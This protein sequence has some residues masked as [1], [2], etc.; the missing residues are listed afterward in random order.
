MQ[1]IR[2]KLPAKMREDLERLQLEPRL[3]HFIGSVVVRVVE[4]P[5]SGMPEIADQ[6]DLVDG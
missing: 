5:R 3:T 1:T 6:F 4:H 2:K